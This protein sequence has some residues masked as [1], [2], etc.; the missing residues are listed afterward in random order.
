MMFYKETN[1]KETPIGKIP[2]DWEVV[3]VNEI[4]IKIKAGGTPLTS[5]KEYYGGNIPF[6]KIEDL[7]TSHKYL[8][9]TLTTITEE[10]LRNSSA[11]LVPP[12]SLL[13]AIYGSIG[14]V[15]INEIEVATNQAILGIIPNE[16]KINVEFLYYLLTYLKPYLERYAKQTTQANLTAE[17][18]KNLK[19]PLPSYS[20]QQ[21]I[22]EILS[23]VD[24]AIQKTNEIIAKTERLKKGLMQELLTK[25]IGHK[26]FKET[27][28]G[29][30]PKE[31][32][33]STLS[34]LINYEKG[35]R[36][37]KLF[38]ER[39]SHHFVPYLKAEYLRGLESP[40]WC[41][42][43][44]V[45]ILRVKKTDIIMIWDGSYS[46][47]VFIGFEGVLASTMIKIMPKESLIN[48]KYLY[49]W[50]KKH[51]RI[52]HSTT[53]GTGIPHVNKKIFENLLIPIPPISEQQKIVEILSTVDKKLE[54]E[55]NRKRK[56][57]RIKQGLMDLLLTGKIRVKVDHKNKE[58]MIK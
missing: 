51:S 16:K 56:L 13:V 30:I 37:S 40:E 47:E 18:I 44:E 10:G 28:I 57:E 43:T 21:K 12:K 42:P 7:T 38:K 32:K 20:E 9:S 4:C 6:V 46:G 22:A 15:A 58:E 19:V 54:I 36:P 8:K 41:D 29:K 33:I 53:V 26:E 49:Y 1:F 17:I 5:K 2:E 27:P 14:A 34:E 45:N 3:R 39:T 25:G 23:T 31:W 52:L 55:R 11:W 48:N 50:L 35:K 24:E